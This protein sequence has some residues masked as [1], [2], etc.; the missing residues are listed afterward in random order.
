MT[1]LDRLL[2]IEGKAESK[3]IGCR[4]YRGISYR[5]WQEAEPRHPRLGR[6]WY[7]AIPDATPQRGGCE[8]S[9]EEAIC[10][11]CDTIDRIYFPLAN[12]PA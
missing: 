4:E 10:V 11:A 12:R 9:E 2:D 6:R 8:K 1:T 7:W 3:S 5:L